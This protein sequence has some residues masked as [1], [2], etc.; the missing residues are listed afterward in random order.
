MSGIYQPTKEIHLLI[1]KI[2]QKYDLEIEIKNEK[3]IYI[4]NN[5]L[6]PVDQNTGEL[7]KLDAPYY[8][9]IQASQIRQILVVL[10]RILAKPYIEC[11][12]R[13]IYEGNII[14][15]DLLCQK[16]LDGLNPLID[17][18]PETVLQEL[19]EVLENLLK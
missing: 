17:L 19:V 11:D 3:Y 18:E 12:H 9:I 5:I 7:Q 14:T 15:A 1:P 4:N 13:R 10:E 2:N 6:L 16:W 8:P